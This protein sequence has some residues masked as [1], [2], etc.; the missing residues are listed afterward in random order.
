[1]KPV[2]IGGHHIGP[3][4]PC[5]VIAEAGVNHNG[6]V[7]L[8]H[9]L[10][11]EAKAAGADAVK[12][13][14]FVT[15]ELVTSGAPK[16]AYQTTT[17]GGP[18]AQMPMLKALELTAAEQAEIKKHCDDIGI[19]YLCTPYDQISVEMLDRLGVAAYKIAST[20]TTNIPLLR[21]VAAVGRPVILSTGVSTLSEI[22]DAVDALERVR[23]RLVLLHCTSQ[24]PAPPEEANLRAIATLALA[25]GCPTGYSDHT[26]GI[27][28]AGWAVAAGACLV[29]KHFTLDRTLKGPDHRSSI[30][31]RGLAHLVRSLRLLE[32]ALGNGVKSPAAS[33]RANKVAMQKSLVARR[34]IAAGET[35]RAEDLT[36]KRPGHGLPPKWFDRVVGL[37]AAHALAAD[38]IISLSSIDWTDCE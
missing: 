12:F 8:A 14:A 25:F 1:M 13:Q 9:Q 26:V 15:E 34:A 4:C 30:E 31:P 23:D 37:K 28:L 10:V 32:V 33:E 21:N 17:T 22:E 11:D 7:A 2:D 36:C 5:Y 29:E 3:G 24:Y 16:A 38:Q 19:T 20:D 27:E 6:E 18:G 35:I